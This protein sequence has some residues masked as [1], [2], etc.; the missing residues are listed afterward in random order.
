MVYYAS[1]SFIFRP[2]CS[3]IKYIF[4][5]RVWIWWYILENSLARSHRICLQVKYG[6]FFISFLLFAWFECLRIYF[7]LRYVMWPYDWMLKMYTRINWQT[8]KHYSTIQSPVHD[9][10]HCYHCTMYFYQ[11]DYSILLYWFIFSLIFSLI[12]FLIFSLCSI[13]FFPCHFIGALILSLFRP[14]FSCSRLLTVDPQKRMTADQA[15][16]HLWV[17]FLE[18]SSVRFKI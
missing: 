18:I 5:R 3:Y 13:Y 7:R 16:D 14:D 1:L 11:C 9:M 10:Y 2:L 15:L 17:R 12:F 6:L 8:V 4:L